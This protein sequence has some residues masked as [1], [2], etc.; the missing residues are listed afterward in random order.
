MIEFSDKEIV[1]CLRNR[2]SYVV[3]YLSDRYLPMVRLMVTQMGGSSEDAKDIFQDGLVIMLEKIDNDQF[4]LTCKFKTFLYS[5]C[6]NLW[7]S[8]LEKRKAATNYF[9][10]RI[11]VSSDHDFTEI[12]DNQLY[13]KMFYEVFETLDPV[14][15]EILNLYWQELSPMEIADKLGYTYGYVR[16]K[17]CECQ[18][19][20]MRR[21]SNHPDYK[22]IKKTEMAAM[23]VI[24]E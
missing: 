2:Q 11:E 12:Y 22:Q 3:R 9:N 20:L 24:N 7:K 18:G 10:R 5:V 14:C 23:Q 6:E 15:K 21:I 4:V 1:E 16:K 17:K 19:E 13:E 8:I